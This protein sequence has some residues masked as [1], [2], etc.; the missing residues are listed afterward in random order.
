MKYDVFISH[1]SEDKEDFVRPL[2][3]EL[4]RLGITVW[5]D[6]FV[7]EIGDSLSE[8]I[9][10]GLRDSS[11]GLVV[12]SK[13]FF[14]KN[15]TKHELRSLTQK[16]NEKRRSILPIWHGVSKTNV[17]DFSPALSDLVALN[18]AE[19]IDRIANK[20][21]KAVSDRRSDPKT[22]ASFSKRA[23]IPSETEHSQSTTAIPPSPL[24]SLALG[25]RRWNQLELNAERIAK[26]PGPVLITGES[27]TGKSTLAR[28]IHKHSPYSDMTSVYVGCG[29]FNITTV[30][31]VLFGHS[32]Q[33]FTGARRA[34]EGIF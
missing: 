28:W 30:D 6:D 8:S 24:L 16:H 2:A 34:Q 23:L 10:A 12:L 1:A 7:L 4:Q 26:Q 21:H 19:G 14:L 33:A 20:I 17:F 15:W 22:S 18:S 5:L 29:E 3:T 9:E 11:F 32:D 31:A 13:Y 25:Y 27:G